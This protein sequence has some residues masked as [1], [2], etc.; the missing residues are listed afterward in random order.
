MMSNHPFVA[1]LRVIFD[2]VHYLNDEERGVVWEEVIIMLPDHVSMIMLSA[3]VPN[4]MEVANWIGRTKKKKVTVVS[5]MKRPVPLEHYILAKGKMFK[6]MD[7]KGTFLSDQL[8]EAVKD[9][10]AEKDK[11]NASGRGRGA[12]RG[13]RGGGRGGG[14]RGKDR[15]GKSYTRGGG[16]GGPN[17]RG[18]RPPGPAGRDDPQ[19]WKQVI[20]FLNSKE[21]LPVVIFTFGKHKCESCGYG[22]GSTD[23]TTKAEKAEIE[24][25][26]N[27]SIRRL[28]PG[29][30]QIP[31][32]LRIK[33]LLKRGI[34]V[35]HAGLLP[36]IKEVVEMLFGQTLIKVL[37]ATETFAM[38]VNM[39]TRTVIFNG[40]RKND[41]KGFRELLAGE[42][43]QMSGRA[44]RRGLDTVGLVFLSVGDGEAIPAELNLRTMMKGR[45]TLLTSQFRLTYNM[46]LNLLRVEDLKVEDMIKR[47]FSEFDSQKD[48]GEVERLLLQGR[49]RL[50]KQQLLYEQF[51][52][53]STIAQEFQ[54]EVEQFHDFSKQLADLNYDITLEIKHKAPERLQTGR[55]VVCRSRIFGLAVGVLLYD[56]RKTASELAGAD[57]LK[58]KSG[59]KLSMAALMSKKPEPQKQTEEAPGAELG[60]S[61]IARALLIQPFGAGGSDSGA[62]AAAAAAVSKG[63]ASAAA[64]CQRICGHLC[65]F[66]EVKPS[67]LVSVT[68][69][70][71]DVDKVEL[72]GKSGPSGPGVLEQAV[73]QLLALAEAAPDG[74]PPP[75]SARELKIAGMEFV[76]AYSARNHL[77]E[78][79]RG[80]RCWRSATFAEHYRHVHKIATLRK[81]STDRASQST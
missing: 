71:L 51:L 36:I 47:S 40:I 23:L 66:V 37:F 78:Q 57:S 22:L 65:E 8:K 80:V 64:R 30:R 75:L 12:D 53:S 73:Q 10:K 32:I 34:G 28:S 15:G 67:D 20:D 6:L 11:A 58:P 63:D 33:E 55:V 43:T 54:L 35:H 52:Q 74:L 56:G 9:D 4:T 1:S 26:V 60:E 45:S 44:G 19:F 29:D 62:A 17:R 68:A 48:S 70:V 72:G 13:G 7:A 21:V 42:Y 50:D 16:G 49:R 3:T 25:F 31:Q 5:T 41:G 18:G 14:G 77:A 24:A 61:S 2:E 39:P 27:N 79:V 76:E 69:D 59:A 81:V 46:I 38:G